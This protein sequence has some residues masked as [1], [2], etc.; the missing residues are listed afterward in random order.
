M[1][2]QKAHQDLIGYFISAAL[3][4]NCLTRNFKLLLALENMGINKENILYFKV[5]TCQKRCQ[6][7]S[8]SGWANWTARVES[9]VLKSFAFV[10]LTRKGSLCCPSLF[11]PDRW[12]RTH[13]SGYPVSPCIRPQAV[14]PQAR[15]SPQVTNSS[16]WH[17]ILHL[18][19]M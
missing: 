12:Q 4:R 16:A 8:Y 13:P 18:Q 10:W 14:A 9:I 6:H 3:C 17:W 15:S 5:I 7:F 11:Q 1:V 19:R 2:V